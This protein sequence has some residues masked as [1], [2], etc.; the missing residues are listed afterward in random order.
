[1]RTFFSS[2]CRIHPIKSF[3]DTL[4]L[5]AI[6]RL[7]L[8]VG[9]FCRDHDMLEKIVSCRLLFLLSL[10]IPFWQTSGTNNWCSFCI[11]HVLDSKSELWALSNDNAWKKRECECSLM[12]SY[13]I[14]LLSKFR[15]SLCCLYIITTLEWE[16]FRLNSVILSFRV[17]RFHQ[18]F[19]DSQSERKW[20]KKAAFS[21]V[22][23]GKGEQKTHEHEVAMVWMSSNE[24]KKCFSSFSFS[25][26]DNKAFFDCFPCCFHLSHTH[27]H[28]RRRGDII[29]IVD[30]ERRPNGVA[31]KE[32][33]ADDWQQKFPSSFYREPKK[34]QLCS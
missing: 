11:M 30:L 14:P 21:S 18:H 19:W 6:L 24:K 10:E 23:E 29:F 34:R 20:T 25:V 26:R 5:H 13:I 7:E 9:I 27:T 12:R 31:Q 1:M 3:E 28:T 4:E 16:V 2:S 33:R 15:H 17:V 32:Q 22:Y 8:N